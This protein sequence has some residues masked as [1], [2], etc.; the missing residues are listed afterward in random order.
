MK[1]IGKIVIPMAMVSL[2]FLAFAVL[3]PVVNPTSGVAI[4]LLTIQTWIEKVGAFMLAVG[5]VIAV[6]FITY[7]GIKLVAS[8][9]D[10]TGVKAAHEIIKNGIIGALVILGVGAILNTLAGVLAN[11][12]F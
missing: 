5:V 4:N 10:P 11:T 7:G 8:H 3:P 9:G 12:F 6:I 2:P 1:T